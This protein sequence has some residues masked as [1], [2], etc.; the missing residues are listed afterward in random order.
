MLFCCLQ[1]NI[2][3]LLVINTSSSSPVYNKRHRL[4]ATSVNNL[5][6]FVTAECIALGSRTVHSMRWSQILAEN[7]LL[8]LHSMPPLGGPSWNTAITFGIEKLQW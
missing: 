4:P 7:R 2:D 5:P 8:H 6:R 3:W 1:L